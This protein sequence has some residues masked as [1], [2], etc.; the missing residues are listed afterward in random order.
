MAGVTH[1]EIEESVEE[2]DATVHHLARYRLKA[3]L[4]VPRP[5]NRKQDK[6]KLEAFKKTLPTICN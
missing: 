1:I 2:L 6:E 3:K 4:K 5:Q